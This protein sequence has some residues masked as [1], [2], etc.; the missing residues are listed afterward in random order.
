MQ[1]LIDA[2]F[3]SFKL[4]V[5]VFAPLEVLVKL[6]DLAICKLKFLLSSFDVSQNV[7]VGLISTLSK[8]L[9]ELDLSFGALK[10]LLEL[11]NFLYLGFN[12]LLLLLK[13]VS[14]KQALLDS[15]LSCGWS[16]GNRLDESVTNVVSS[17]TS[18][19]VVVSHMHD[20]LV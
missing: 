10:L 16:I 5:F 7:V 4:L 19:L 15:T 14:E 13:P 12:F 8:S 18:H 2:R 3:L 20:S 11:V 6:V 1:V 9:V 17:I